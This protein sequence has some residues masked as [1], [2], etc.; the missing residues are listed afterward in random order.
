MKRVGGEWDEDDWRRMGLRWL[1]ETGM[2]M[3]GGERDEDSRK[4]MG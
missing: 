3:V 1:E 4:R 2:I